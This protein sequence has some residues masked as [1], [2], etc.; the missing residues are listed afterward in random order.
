MSARAPSALL[1]PAG[2]L[3]C[4][5]CCAAACATAGAATSRIDEDDLDQ[6]YGDKAL[7]SIATGSPQPLRRAPSV[8]SV[9]TAEDIA[10][11]GATQLD[12]ALLLVPGLHVGR[13]AIGYVP[14]YWVRGIT[15]SVSNPQ[16]L[17]LH[18][19]FPFINI[20]NGDKGNQW[21][22]MP[23]ANV[24]RIE[25]IRGPGSALYGANAYAGVINVITRPA[26]ATPS[27][28][29]GARVGSFDTQDAWLLH[30]GAIGGFDLA[31]S[32]QIGRSDGQRR[33][34]EADNQT[35]LD[36]LFGTRASLAP[37][38]VDT[39]RD[40]LDATLEVARGAWRWRNDYKRREHV[41]T[42][43]GV[44]S[45]LDPTSEI[46]AEW[47]SSELS[48]S[49]PQLA[50]HWSA[51]A[52]LGGQ[53]SA[54]VNPRL[55]LFPPGTRFPTGLFPEGVIGGP[56]RWQRGLRASA[57]ALYSGFAG[58]Q[59]RIGAG[60]D[61]VELYRAETWKNNTLNAAGLPALTGPQ[62]EYS[63]IQPHILPA[64]RRVHHLYLQDEWSFARDWTLT[65][66]VRHDRYSDAGPTT[67]PRLALVWDAS[68]ALTLKLL[69]G[70]AFRAPAFNEQYG[71]NPVASGN[72]AL[73][74]ETIRTWEAALKWQPALEW[75][76]T[77]NAFRHRMR[78]II[79]TVPNPAP[80]PGAMWRNIGEQH[81]RGAELELAW[82]PRRTLRFSGHFSYQ[83]STDPATGR[84]IGY[85]PHRRL[86]ARAEWRPAARWL[87][88]A[89][90]N[91]VADRRRAAGDARPPIADYTTLDL[92][93]RRLRGDAAHFGHWEFAAAVRNL[94]NADVREPSLAP[95]VIPN[96]LPLAPRAFYLQASREF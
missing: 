65:A 49:E 71:I 45:A 13:S 54:D 46:S 9:V 20:Y 55:V 35:R 63:A 79:R 62:V 66:G 3:A 10:N 69:Y 89:Q 70:S 28:T 50:P 57:Y 17:L 39:G 15:G 32:L 95:G 58:H 77:L 11:A 22:A 83:V 52:A 36:R 64:R 41:G 68:A 12:E 14:M 24:A 59:V 94:T 44:S 85:A 90:L 73:K 53:W 78:D 26:S 33:I 61:D 23:L 16:L 8:A 91:H 2:R 93:L 19:G 92:T 43:A 6:A 51:G 75:Q 82:E 40:L 21:T 87:A 67:H 80:S 48:W 96:D 31:A 86:Y 88:S 27:T 76:L 25:V 7:I 47:F 74:P 56:N 38:P 84:D 72:A 1:H 4:V 37:G 18:N 30:S 81:G 34:I 5:L 42:G 60:H 29:L